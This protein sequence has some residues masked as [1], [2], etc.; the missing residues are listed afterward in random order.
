MDTT[1]FLS[2]KE[3]L[4]GLYQKLDILSVYAY[5]FSS[6]GIGIEGNLKAKKTKQIL[7]LPSLKPL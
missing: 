5:E 4:L 2:A 6:S 1:F 3:L 7:H